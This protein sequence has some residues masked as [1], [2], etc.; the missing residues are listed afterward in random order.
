MFV[1]IYKGDNLNVMKKISNKYSNKIK[2][3]YID[4]PYNNGENY[5]YYNDKKK[6]KWLSDLSKRIVLLRNFLSD[7]G[8]IWVSINDSEVHYLKVEMDKIFGR[9]NFINTIVWNHKKSRENRTIFS[10]NCEYILVYAYN[11]NHF[12]KVR[13]L[14]PPSTEQ[15]KRYK[16]P[17]NDTRGPWQSISLNVQDG[18]AAKSQYYG[19]KGPNGQLHYPPKG[20]VWIYN[21]ERMAL[22]IEKNN[23]WFGANGNGVPRKK[24]FLSESKI[25]LTPETLWLSEEVGSTEESKKE[26]LKEFPDIDAFDTPK[27]VKLLERIIEISSNE[28]DIIMDVYSGSGSTGV[29]AVSKKRNFIGIEIGDHAKDIIFERVNRINQKKFNNKININII[30]STSDI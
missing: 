3:I 1:E 28:D 20:R 26:F 15:L 11:I 5:K 17:D 22:E 25:G 24:K 16:N 7:D 29:A 4:P 12:K 19:I 23:I 18:H 8:S 30:D 21:A 13:N 6:K 27:P 2:C 10:R 14:L 9:E